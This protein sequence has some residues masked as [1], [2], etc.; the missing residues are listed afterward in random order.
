MKKNLIIL[1]LVLTLAAVTNP[2]LDAHREA[3]TEVVNDETGVSKGDKDL[4]KLVGGSIA[5]FMVNNTVSRD[6]Y[7][8][9]SL[10]KLKLT[11]EEEVIGYGAF[12]YVYVKK[13]VRDKVNTGN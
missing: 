5:R 2:D 3:V 12:G 8:F 9:F 13:E 4:G 6:D 11:G 10:T 7:F 1:V